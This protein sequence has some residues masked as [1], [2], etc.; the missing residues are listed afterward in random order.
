MNKLVVKVI[1]IAGVLAAASYGVYALV[2]TVGEM[3]TERHLTSALQ[4]V[5]EDGDALREDVSSDKVISRFEDWGGGGLKAFLEQ[6]GYYP[7]D[8][9]IAMTKYIEASITYSMTEAENDYIIAL[10]DEDY[11]FEK[12]IDIYVFLKNTNHGMEL[13]RE[14]YDNSTDSSTDFGIENAY[15]TLVHGDAVPLTVDDVAAYVAQ[16][17]STDDILMAFELSLKGDMSVRDILDNLI[18]GQALNGIIADAY[19]E[20]EISPEVFDGVENLRHANTIIMFARK[21][22]EKI[23]DTVEYVDGEITIKQEISEKLDSKMERVQTAK[24]VANIKDTMED[25]DDLIVKTKEKVP[26]LDEATIEKYLENGM[27]IR[28]IED[29][30]KIQLEGGQRS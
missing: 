6:K 25:I 16:G 23:T 29:Q 30:A 14:I 2:E 10:V 21:A 28:E 24:E 4:L 27:R 13:M 9:N 11:D 18:I 1:L 3:A 17:L 5:M 15:E 8:V 19:S 20:E 22:E 26:N 7:D 12:L